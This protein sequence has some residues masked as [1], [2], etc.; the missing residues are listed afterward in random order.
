MTL[1]HL[2]ERMTIVQKQTWERDDSINNLD[3]NDNYPV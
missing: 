1:V 3:V 2:E